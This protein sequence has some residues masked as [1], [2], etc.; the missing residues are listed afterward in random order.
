MFFLHSTRKGFVHIPRTGGS[1]IHSQC[2]F[3]DGYERHHSYHHDIPEEFSHY[4]WHTV[5]RDPVERFVSLYRFNQINQKIST[6]KGDF[7]SFIEHVWNGFEYHTRPQISFINE[8]THCYIDPVDCI[9]AL[10]GEVTG[11]PINYS[12]GPEPTVSATNKRSIE[13]LYSQDVDLF[14]RLKSHKSHE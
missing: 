13:W 2:K 9:Y 5:I 12:E 6:H 7:E 10:G 3:L 14:S 4:E 11:D 8:Q 1:F